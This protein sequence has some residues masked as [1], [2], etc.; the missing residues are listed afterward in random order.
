M[1]A[2]LEKKVRQKNETL[3]TGVRRH[4]NLNCVNQLSIKLNT[5]YE[6]Q[7]KRNS[8]EW[9]VR[10]SAVCLCD[11]EW[12]KVEKLN[13]R[14]FSYSQY[15]YSNS[16]QYYCV[17][18]IQKLTQLPDEMIKVSIFNMKKK[19]HQKTRDDF[20]VW[21]WLNTQHAAVTAITAAHFVRGEPFT[22]C[23]TVQSFRN[24]SLPFFS[25]NF[26]SIRFQY[27]EKPNYIWKLRWLCE[28]ERVVTTA[29]SR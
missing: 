5:G 6:F 20:N 11:C 15:V 17:A 16:T 23:A 8:I 27:E 29:D 2:G 1:S 26:H 18:A 13:Y 12:E 22:V 10:R 25:W 24:F 4:P 21:I 3:W 14:S 19:K 7:Q 28:R 9:N